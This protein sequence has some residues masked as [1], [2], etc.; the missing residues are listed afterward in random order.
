MKISD[1][2]KTIDLLESINPLD[3]YAYERAVLA[4]LKLGGLPIFINELPIGM[5]FFHSRTH[6]SEDFFYKVSDI[7]IPPQEYVKNFARCNRPF[8]S[9]FY[10]SETRPTSY[11]ELVEYWAESKKI[12]ESLKVTLG[13]WELKKTINS[14]IV[15]TPDPAKRISE[16]DKLHGLAFDTLITKYKGEELESQKLFY[17][18][19]FE[20]FRKPAKKD[21]K[22]YIITSAYCN[23]AFMQANG[24]ADAIYFPSVPFQENGINLCINKDYFKPDNL[25]LKL[26][27]RNEFTITEN[28]QGKHSFTES[29]KIETKNIRIKENQIIWHE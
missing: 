4:Y 25:E 24:Q 16:F 20:K 29:G 13:L 12:G 8:Q 17:Q 5:S 22:T 23:I 19:L 21:L 28:E 11:M 6:I 27:V 2:Q 3:D 10:C 7:S 15:T 14:I 18:F 26:A 1:T 9:V